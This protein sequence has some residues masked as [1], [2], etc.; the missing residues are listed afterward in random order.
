MKNA[1]IVNNLYWR[2]PNFTGTKNRYAL[3]NINLKVKKGET[4]GIIGRNDAGK[5]T[6]C[7]VISGIIPYQSR[8]LPEDGPNYFKGLIKIN[9]RAI[10]RVVKRDH[11][12]IL[13]CTGVAAPD[14]GLVMENPDSQFL[15]PTIRQ[16]L[17]LGLNFMGLD[18]D[19]IETRIKSALKVVGIPELYN[20]IDD[21]HPSQLSGGQKQRLIIACFV[22]M[23][24]KIMVLDEPTSDLDP[25]GKLQVIESIKKIK[26]ANNST[27]VVVE[28]DPDIIAAVADRVAL[29]DAG[30]LI[31]VGKVDEV[32]N[33]KNLIKR[34]K[35]RIPDIVEL[36][37]L[38]GVTNSHSA[39]IIANKLKSK[40]M[41]DYSTSSMLVKQKESAESVIKTRKLNFSYKYGR[42]ALNDINLDIKKGEF[43]AI[44]GQNGSGK[45]TL[46]KVLSGIETGF[47]GD[48]RVFG[49]DLSKKKNRHKAPS[50]VGYI[51]QNPD[52]QLFNK[53]V[54]EEVAY[55]LDTR[56]ISKGSNERIR[57][58]LS[59]MGILSKANE[60]PAFLSKGQ[61]RRLLLACILSR[62]PEIM[63]IDE[64][65]AGQDNESTMRIMRILKKLNGAG[66]TI[67]LIT[68]DMHIVAECCTRSIVLKDGKKIYDGRTDALFDAKHIIAS[69]SLQVPDYIKVAKQ[70]QLLKATSKLVTSK[71]QLIK[72]LGDD[73]MNQ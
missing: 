47:T 61:K 70:L 49:K 14:V 60:N 37:E 22:A 71:M 8:L 30:K 59:Q 16:E 68:H 67:L 43:V 62:N 72:M 57:S 40:I 19:V 15:T 2:Y 55:G 39:S 66:K 36:A 34:Y 10:S 23:A 28:Q 48:V 45:S 11:G 56:N 54:S 17:L 51:F 44:L 41:V 50:I 35:I 21:I 5:T 31:K 18:K 33:D 58:L 12:T 69:A 26:R 38:A 29:L 6:L 1:I 52:Q 9:G 65:M 20:K 46:G 7:S 73:S 25:A 24:P 63:V 13:E 64:P 4:L 27:L 53:S 42:K 32:Y 3:K